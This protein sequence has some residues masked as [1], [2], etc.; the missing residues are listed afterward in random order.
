MTKPL[1]PVPWESD[2]QYDQYHFADI[3][4]MALEELI[5]E[6][7]YRRAHL[8]GVPPDDWQRLRVKALEDDLARR[9]WNDNA[10]TVSDQQES[11]TATNPP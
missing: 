2:T 10:K 4:D 11:K 7:N 3:P 1:I 8:L 5:D 9:K 6:L